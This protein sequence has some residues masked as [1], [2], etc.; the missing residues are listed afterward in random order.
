MKLV[1]LSLAVFLLGAC[2]ARSSDDER[3]RAIIATAEK[4]AEARD[5]SDVLDV[6]VTDYSD[7]QGFDRA[8]LRNFLLAYF[9]ANPRV[10]VFTN[11]QDLQ[12]PV[13]GLARARIEVA[14]LPAGDRAT[15]QVEFRRQGDRWLVA[16]ADRSR[17]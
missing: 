7:S 9:L 4:A 8:Q 6:V 10:E 5:T 11:V 1:T 3:V 14:V 15:L 16:R 2:G 12:F 17:E 13:D